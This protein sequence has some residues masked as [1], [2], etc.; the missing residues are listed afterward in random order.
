MQDDVVKYFLRL[1]SI[2]S[3]S[4]N[5]RAMMDVLRKDLE[6]LGAEVLE[7]SC[8]KHNDGNAGNLYAFI[9]GKINKKPILFC[10]HADTVVPGNGIKPIVENG[11]IFTDGTTILG[12]DDKSG[13]AEA[14][15]AIKKI[16]DSGIDHAPIEVLI[17]VSE[18]I[19]LIGAK[20]FNKGMLKSAFGYA[21]DSH[22]VGE[23]IFGAPSQNSFI[24]TI[25]GKEAHA[26]VEP[27]KGLNAIRIASEA[28][29]AMP[30][31]RIDLETTCNIGKIYGG[32]A[33]NIVPNKVVIKGEAR[34]H[35]THKLEQV[36]ADI[37]RAAEQTVARY[38]N[39]V[40]KAECSFIMDT[41]YHTFSIPED[42]EVL[43]LAQ[44]AL[45][46]LGIPIIT[47]KGGGGSDANIINIAGVPMIIVGTGMN[48]VH[49][50]SE[51]IQI[52]Q[53]HKG[54]SFIEELIRQYS[55]L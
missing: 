51:D 43:Q 5:E 23:L 33:T 22:Q 45:R 2:D 19:G 15:I 3:E 14:L 55:E 49:T 42:S 17:T 27:E 50:V 40:G 8:H 1:V 35:N 38:N 52:D 29:S 13:I 24:V 31:G 6:E 34:S 10:A 48:K 18:E 39:E 26:G 20:C 21:L 4:K 54:V 11:R 9:P 41:E 37:R 44:S 12:G 25:Y 32:S 46:K 36:C 30:N 7:D 28:I 16:K 47:K 53:L